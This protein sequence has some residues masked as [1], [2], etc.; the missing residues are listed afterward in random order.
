[1]QEQIALLQEEVNLLED[2]VFREMAYDRQRITRLERG[3]TLPCQKDRGEVLK[4]LLISHGGRML[5]ADARKVM[6]LSKATFSSLLATMRE[7][8]EVRPSSLDKRKNILI[9]K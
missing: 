3:K 2:R 4:A 8:I 6:R 1:M 5:Q 9:L 7:E